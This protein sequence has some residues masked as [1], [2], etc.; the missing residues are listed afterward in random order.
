[1]LP[2]WCQDTITVI[3]APWVAS[4]GSKV[5]DWAEAATHEV[6]GCSVQYA[7]TQ[8]SDPAFRAQASATVAAV[9]C[10]PGADVEEGDRIMFEGVTYELDGAPM[11]VRSPFGGASHVLLSVTARR[12]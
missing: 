11:A 8:T 12:G 2:S 9:Y 4:R 10:P 3:R 6:A 1:M 7:S 5:R